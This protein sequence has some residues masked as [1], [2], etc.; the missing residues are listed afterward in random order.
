MRSAIQL[1]KLLTISDNI[2]DAIDLNPSEQKPVAINEL[3][4]ACITLASKLD[5]HR[6]NLEN[7]HA[8]TS[9][10]AIPKRAFIQ[11]WKNL[12]SMCLYQVTCGLEMPGYTP[13][14]SFRKECTSLLTQQL[15]WHKHGLGPVQSENAEIAEVWGHIL[16]FAE[17]LGDNSFHAELLSIAEELIERGLKTEPDIE[18]LRHNHTA[19]SPDNRIA[20]TLRLADALDEC[21]RRALGALLE[22]Q[23]GCESEGVWKRILDTK[24]Y[25]SSAVR[26]ALVGLSHLDAS[27]AAPYLI[28]MLSLA[29]SPKC[30]ENV[31]AR[32]IASIENFLEEPAAPQVFLSLF[33]QEEF[34][35]IERSAIAPIIAVLTE[36]LEKHH[37]L[38]PEAQRA[39]SKCGTDQSK[40]EVVMDR[41]E[42]RGV[43]W[44]PRVLA[45]LDHLIN[46]RGSA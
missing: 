35:H 14:E 4:S 37:G 8:S 24:P 11:K 9:S 40:R 6:N 18:I 42:G 1:D 25:R 34:F 17:T 44:E 46:S 39:L 21:E 22:C 19:E 38:A 26:T 45:V 7:L 16:S 23:F 27:E 43:I 3:L 36:R 28:K 20:E 41:Y 31:R 30:P 13:T 12:Y 29:A 2:L 32:L 5:E 15:S 10:L 33:D